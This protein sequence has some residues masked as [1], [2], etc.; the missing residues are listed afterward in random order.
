MNKK[1]K[2]A[3]TSEKEFK[4]P[5]CG[6][7]HRISAKFCSKSGKKLISESSGKV[8]QKSQIPSQMEEIRTTLYS[9]KI[10]DEKSK[11]PHGLDPGKSISIALNDMKET[12]V[13]TNTEIKIERC[14]Q[15]GTPSSRI[16]A[17]FCIACGKLMRK[18]EYIVSSP[19]I[20]VSVSSP[21]IPKSPEKSAVHCPYSDCKRPVKKNNTYCPHCYQRLV[22]CPKCS[23]PND[24]WKNRC[25]VCNEFI[26]SDLRD[27]PMFKGNVERTGNTTEILNPPFK[28]KWVYPP[29]G[30][31]ARILSSPIIYKGKAYYGSCDMNLHALNQYTGNPLWKRP[32]NGFIVSTPAI[33]NKI[34]Y[35]ASC[36][37]KI[38]ASDTEKGKPVWVFPGR[39]SGRIGQ[40]TGELLAAKEGLFIF[41]NKGKV[42]RID[43]E[44]GNLIWELNTGE[45]S[46]AQQYDPQSCE[47]MS[48]PAIMEG[49][50]FIATIHGRVLC[51]DVE[52]GA[53]KWRFPGEKPVPHRF[54]STPLLCAKHCYIPDRSGNFYAISTKTGE[55]AWAYTVSLKG[56][57]EGSASVGE[58]KIVVGAQ[59]EYLTALNLHSG[60][61]V[62]RIKNERINLMDSIFSTPAIT[63]NG[64]VFYGSDTGYLYCRNIKNGEEIWKERLD[65]PI[66]SSPA[67]S[68]GFLY[69]TTTKG[70][71]YAFRNEE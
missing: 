21:E 45:D 18:Q 9:G 63:G 8:R 23:T 69:V 6:N 65:S 14:P 50:L 35:V 55:D 33:Y 62:W 42:F 61:E 43:A 66:R 2:E 22:F 40:V 53:I 56:V 25:S 32:T 37:G 26:S 5:H 1:A 46:V 12:S 39:R 48:S 28:R 13:K 67:I 64:L 49:M 59:N 41:N 30:D 7:M 20:K 16:G 27:W 31:K 19:E 4:C 44:K 38:Y 71:L 29:A 24:L 60:G 57:I 11:Y 15:C 47:L 70:F 51:I 54:I 58:G 17:K 10:P 68:D 3:K 34:V 36:D 52:T